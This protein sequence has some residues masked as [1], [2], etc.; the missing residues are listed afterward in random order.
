MTNSTVMINGVHL[1]LDQIKVIDPLHITNQNQDGFTEI[2]IKSSKISQKTQYSFDIWFVGKNGGYRTFRSNVVSYKG[3]DNFK[4][5]VK[6][7][8]EYN[9]LV[10]N[11]KQYHNDYKEKI[12]EE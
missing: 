10:E 12:T 5:D 9:T 2:F 1:R 11:W 3:V 8:N 4:A 6:F 7:K